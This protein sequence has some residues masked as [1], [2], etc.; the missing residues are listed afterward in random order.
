M[1]ERDITD[2]QARLKHLTQFMTKEQ[3]V[4]LG[5]EAAECITSM[6]KEIAD[7]R[8]SVKAFCGPYAVQFGMDH[9]YP[10]GHLHPVH[11]DILLCA[12][13]RMDDFVRHSV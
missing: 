12:G 4:D 1:K 7:L 13:A 8:L 6:R 10:E 11:Y 3:L 2:L 9:G 5:E